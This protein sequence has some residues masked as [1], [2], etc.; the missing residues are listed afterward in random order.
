MASFAAARG[1]GI[2]TGGMTIGGVVCAPSFPAVVTSVMAIT[3]AARSG[4]RMF[5]A[6][7]QSPREGRPF[8]R[9]AVPSAE[10]G[11]TFVGGVDERLHRRSR[12][13][14]SPHCLLR[15]D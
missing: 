15:Q 6:T 8:E 11:G 2:G 12:I 13:E 9:G 1:E 7:R 10:R 14:T 4:N 5:I 3:I